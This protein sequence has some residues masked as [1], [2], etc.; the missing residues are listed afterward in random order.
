M[1]GR[2]GAP[3][4]PAER[5]VG[6]QLE[7]AADRGVA[8]AIRRP[9]GIGC[10]LD[11]DAAVGDAFDIG[12]NT[13]AFGGGYGLHVAGK[14]PGRVGKARVSVGAGRESVYQ[15]AAPSVG[16]HFVDSSAGSIR[17]GE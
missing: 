16:Q 14:A 15:M 8:I 3:T 11:L 6:R 4:L 7:F 2:R 12:F 10:E 9:L 13:A 5:T 1:S 17:V